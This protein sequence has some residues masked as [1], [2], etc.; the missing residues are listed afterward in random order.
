M[1]YDHDEIEKSRWLKRIEP[2][3]QAIY[4]LAIHAMDASS[5]LE[6]IQRAH[7][8]LYIIVD[9]WTQFEAVPVRGGVNEY[10]DRAVFNIHLYIEENPVKQFN[11]NLWIEHIWKTIICSAAAGGLDKQLI[12]RFIKDSFDYGVNH[13]RVGSPEIS[14]D[15]LTKSEPWRR[16]HEVISLYRIP[17]SL[18]V[19]NSLYSLFQLLYYYILNQ[20]SQYLDDYISD[21][22]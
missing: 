20:P 6:A 5:R 19:I 9:G 13:E 3:G 17:Y 15:E 7:D 14:F 16:G 21:I 2:H 8:S 1:N 22:E 10:R 4:N 12:E 18:S 11:W